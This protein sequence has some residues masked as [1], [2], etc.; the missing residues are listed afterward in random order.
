MK[1]AK[2]MI[3]NGFVTEAQIIINSFIQKPTAAEKIKD[4]QEMQAIWYLTEMGDYFFSKSKYLTAY[5]FFKKIHK[6]FIEFVDDQLDFHN[7][8]LRRLVLSDYVK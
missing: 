1:T 8:S 5:C 7:Y 3:R 2:H 6:I 4:M